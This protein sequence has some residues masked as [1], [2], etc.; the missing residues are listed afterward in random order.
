MER[1]VHDSS[2]GQRKISSWYTSDIEFDDLTRAVLIDHNNSV[3]SFP[4]FYCWPPNSKSS[5]SRWKRLFFKKSWI[6]KTGGLDIPARNNEFRHELLH[7]V[8]E[9]VHCFVF[10]FFFETSVYFFSFS[11]PPQ[12][13]LFH[14]SLNR[15]LSFSTSNDPQQ[16]SNDS[17]GCRFHLS[18]S[19]PFFLSRVSFFYHYRPLDGLAFQ[20]RNE[21]KRPNSLSSMC[22][23][24]WERNKSSGGEADL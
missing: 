15:R 14:S 5:S 9:K 11:Q 19:S 21:I 4:H 7:C 20:L 2:I 18:F 13:T 8:V 10:S 16:V 1:W 17:C 3:L 6:A 12:M 23:G 22:V 24:N